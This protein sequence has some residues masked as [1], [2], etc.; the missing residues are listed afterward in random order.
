MSVTTFERDL[1]MMIA[2]TVKITEYNEGDNLPFQLVCAANDK[3]TWTCGE[4][5][6]GKI[7]SIFA[8]KGDAEEEADRKVQYL[9][10]KDHAIKI[11]DG[12]MKENWVPTKVPKTTISYPGMEKL[13]VGDVKLNRRQKRNFPK[14][15]N[16]LSNPKNRNNKNKKITK[17]EED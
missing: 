14:Y 7:T 9:D 15:M 10:D 16:H 5:E 1:T 6:A 11:R 12:L 4:D 13:T 8:F 17:S 2:A 3:I